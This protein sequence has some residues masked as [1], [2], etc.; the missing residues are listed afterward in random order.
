MPRS[1]AQQAAIDKRIG[2]KIGRL[3]LVRECEAP[4]YIFNKKQRNC[5]WVWCR[6]ECGKELPVRM[7]NLSPGA[8]KGQIRSCGCLR[9]ENT[10][11]QRKFRKFNRHPK[12][13]LNA[14]P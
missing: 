6:C 4:E 8:K 9:E 13:G 12:E 5:T 10:E 7:K 2:T 1:A 14:K 11:Y 3:T